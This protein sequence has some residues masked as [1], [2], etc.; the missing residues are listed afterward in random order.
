MDTSESL[1]REIEHPDSQDAVER[2]INLLLDIKN[3]NSPSKQSVEIEVEEPGNLDG[4]NRLKNLL[5]G[6]DNLENAPQRIPAENSIVTERNI[7]IKIDNSPVNQSFEM[8]VKQSPEPVVN[9]EE[10]EENQKVIKKL[11]DLLFGIEDEQHNDIPTLENKQE[12][13]FIVPEIKK[14][15]IE[16]FAE[17]ISIVPEEI[18]NEV[19]INP[20]I[21]TAELTYLVAFNHE[22]KTI[23]SEEESQG[24]LKQLQEILINGSNVSDMQIIVAYLEEKIKNLEQVIYEP[25][26]LIQLLLPLIA[27][28]LSLKVARSKQEIIEAIAP[29]I[30]QM[31][32]AKTL[33]DKP[34]MNAA[35]APILPGAILQ[36]VK[37]SPGEF[38][39]VIAPEM[40]AA[41]KQQI[42]LERD[43]MV[44]ALYPVIGNTISKYM[45][46]A[47]RDI[48]QKVENAFS[49]EGIKRKIRAKTQGVSEAEL[50]FQESMPF[51]V[52]AMFL[53]HKGSGLLI[54]EFQPDENGLESE[55]VAGMLT[56]IRSFVN[57]CIMQSGDVSELDQIDYGNSKIILEVAGYCYLAVVTQ[58]QPPRKFMDKMRYNV[59]A[60]VLRYENKIKDFDGDQSTVPEGV[61][62][63]LKELYEWQ[64]EIKNKDKNKKNPTTLFLLLGGFLG[65]I[66]VF[67]GWNQY[68]EGIKR[69]IEKKTVLALTS[70]PELTI[71]NL[72]VK[73]EKDKLQINGKVPSQY[74]RSQ[75]EKIVKKIAPNQKLDNKIIAV[76]LPAD[77]TVTNAEV[78]R[79]TA[80]FNRMDGVNI[81]S[82]YKDGQVTIQGKLLSEKD[83][84]KI[85]EA[86]AKI[87]GVNTV[88]NMIEVRG[89]R[90][91]IRIYFDLGSSKIKP[92]DIKT[93]IMEVKKFMQR[94]PQQHLRIIGRSDQTGNDAKKIKLAME[95]AKSVQAILISQGVDAK[96]IQVTWT[97]KLSTGIDSNQP[98]WLSR[99]V[100]FQVINPVFTRK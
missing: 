98:L 73:M 7:D 4:M 27:D 29:V 85:T 20:E 47:I 16:T 2:L 48:N 58:G 82:N 62:L 10:D 52:Q 19:S 95:R 99:S 1:T 38:A 11:N 64:R 21:E 13:I 100:E 83:G 55:M 87:P 39:K 84:A 40:G 3:D 12:E 89:L 59:G 17:E 74:L 78:K 23:R 75:A 9:H 76:E 71:Y 32:A 90:L 30:D 80:I 31:I 69:E 22:E 34:S 25:K 53:I 46:E 81:K 77:P 72:T 94:H 79:I 28:L 66:F 92:A 45:A 49:M 56:A 51:I 26:E 43:A 88:T 5:L 41:I 54:A 63:L 33:E 57:D 91:P 67:W 86:F 8:G 61:N 24:K 15:D 35:L 6:T 36:H 68:Q 93:K 50:I 14:P 18:E 97:N 44:D 70:S 65:L 42:L 60:I 96:K 37:D